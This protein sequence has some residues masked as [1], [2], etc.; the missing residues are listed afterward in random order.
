MASTP[1][2]GGRCERLGPSAHICPLPSQSACS[3]R[4]A[5]GRRASGVALPPLLRLHPRGRRTLP[6]L[7]ATASTASSCCACA[8]PAVQNSRSSCA[9]P[10]TSSSSTSTRTTLTFR[11]SKT[12]ACVELTSARAPASAARRPP[13]RSFRHIY[14]AQV[15]RWALAVLQCHAATPVIR[16]PPTLAQV[17]RFAFRL[18]HRL[19]GRWTG[20]AE[21]HVPGVSQAVNDVRVCTVHRA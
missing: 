16:P 11:A 6:C 19:E 2:V 18:L 12:A 13:K 7:R 9:R 4:S 1:T 15:D 5:T 17:G 20:E 10:G 14:V 3:C 21:V 8:R